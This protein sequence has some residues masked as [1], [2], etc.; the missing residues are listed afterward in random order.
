MGGRHCR[1]YKGNVTMLVVDGNKTIS[2]ICH[3]FSLLPIT[4]QSSILGSLGK[5]EHLQAKSTNDSPWLIA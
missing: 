4:K 3:R 1:V 5:A 2:A